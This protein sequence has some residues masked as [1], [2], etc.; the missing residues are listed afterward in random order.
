MNSN[1]S[2]ASKNIYLILAVLTIVLFVGYM[3]VKNHI[4]SGSP[5]L[6]QQ[7]ISTIS[8]DQSQNKDQFDYDCPKDQTAFDVL[9]SKAQIEFK[10]SSF[11]KLVTK[12]NG[13]E[14]GNGKYW[15]YSVNDK[16]ATVGATQYICSGDE[17]IKWELK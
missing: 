13:T 14:Q 11:G 5:N 17:K 12:I 6:D 7:Q 16:E 2:P 1:F 4:L 15:L 9:Q 8:N 3:A 10:E